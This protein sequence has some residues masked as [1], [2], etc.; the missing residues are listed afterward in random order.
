M[1]RETHGKRVLAIDYGRRR[2]GLALSDELGVTAQP[3]TT[4]VRVNRETDFRRLREICRKY[5]V[6]RIIV[7][8]PL[9]L[10]GEAGEMAREAARFA[11]RV[12]KET[13]I[14]TELIDERLSS[15]EAEQTLGETRSRRAPKGPPLDEIAAAILLRDYLDQRK[16]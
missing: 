2:I 13:G 11:A 3:L 6:T 7:G 14:E 4:I 1:A 10:G 16:R 9:L 5:S 12:K 15:W 8:H